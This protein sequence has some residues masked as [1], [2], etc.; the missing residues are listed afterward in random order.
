[1]PINLNMGIS[2]W[3]GRC[4]G[5]VIHITVG[6]IR[7]GYRRPKIMPPSSHY[8]ILSYLNNVLAGGRA[9]R[10]T[11]THTVPVVENCSQKVPQLL[12]LSPQA[13]AC[14]NNQTEEAPCPHAPWGPRGHS[15][16]PCWRNPPQAW[17]HW[18]WSAGLNPQ[19]HSGLDPEDPLH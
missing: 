15:G 12:L 8:P 17:H 14:L 6:L 16:T 5:F 10:V 19:N 18:C 7:N 13:P 1:M 3:R 11:E 4:R 2:F 9:E